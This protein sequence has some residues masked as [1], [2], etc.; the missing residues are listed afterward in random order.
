M[1]LHCGESDEFGG[2]C[3]FIGHSFHAPRW[4]PLLIWVVENPFI[5]AGSR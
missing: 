3:R 5:A 1:H 4:D 2:C